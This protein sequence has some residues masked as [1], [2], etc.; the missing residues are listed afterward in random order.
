MSALLICY[1]KTYCKTEFT[2][3]YSNS[4]LAWYGETQVSLITVT[5]PQCLLLGETLRLIELP[6]IRIPFVTR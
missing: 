3:Q 6:L 2:R 1:I 4:V 5:A